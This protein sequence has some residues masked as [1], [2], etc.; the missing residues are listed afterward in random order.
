MAIRTIII[1]D[2]QNAREN[3]KLILSDFCKDVEVVAEAGSAQEA[4]SLITEHKPNLLFL[5]INMP[6]EDGF[7]LLASIE[8]KNFSVIF[9][10]FFFLKEDGLF[11]RFVSALV[12]NKYGARVSTAIEDI[13]YLLELI[14]LETLNFRYYIL[15]HI[16]M[17]KIRI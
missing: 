3:L 10:T 11:S 1:D 17:V 8:E 13:T 4:R 7:E 9:I 15:P 16:Y 14:H 6:N 5:D 2:E 12:P